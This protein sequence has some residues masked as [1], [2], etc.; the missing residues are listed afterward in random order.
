MSK[1]VRLLSIFSL[2]ILGCS[3]IDSS[4]DISP[5]EIN[6]QVG[7]KWGTA[8]IHSDLHYYDR[9]LL[10]DL[11][12][13]T[14][15]VSSLNQTYNTLNLSFDITNNQKKYRKN[16]WSNNDQLE[17]YDS[18]I[19]DTSIDITLDLA[20]SWQL[21]ID[22]ENTIE[23]HILLM[24]KSY[25]I[26]VTN[27]NFTWDKDTAQVDSMFWDKTEAFESLPSY[28]FFVEDTFSVD[29]NIYSV[30]KS[31]KNS[32]LITPNLGITKQ[33]TSYYES[34]GYGDDPFSIITESILLTFNE[35]QFQEYSYDSLLKK[36]FP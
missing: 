14:Y 35:K 15:H 33:T 12:Y 16:N 29:H 28:D 34:D 17:L 13:L 30:Y 2:L 24:L 5:K 26:D 20:T 6:L 1:F 27:Y 9:Y 18:L 11:N 32:L 7:D 4:K 23:N 25:L 19:T 3:T 8:V 10:Y 36:V 21:P 22:H 31:K